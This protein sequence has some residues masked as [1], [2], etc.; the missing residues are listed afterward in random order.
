MIALRFT[1]S[2]DEQNEVSFD[3]VNKK[4]TPG[5]CAYDITNAV[6]ELMEETYTLAEAIGICALRQVK[7]DNFY[8][9]NS[10]GKYVAF[11]SE[12]VEF[13]RDNQCFTGERCVIA[14]F[15]NYIA[16][17]EIDFESEWYKCKSIELV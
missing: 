1:R 7:F 5:L 4:F 8:A 12:F 16:F 9:H 2:R 6:A 15:N 14:K 10:K 13:E 11:N 17:G 3:N